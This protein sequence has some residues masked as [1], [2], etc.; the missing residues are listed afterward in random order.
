ME[1]GQF[2]LQGEAKV[3]PILRGRRAA[4]AVVVGG[5]LS[6]LTIAL[7]LCK[8]GLRVVLLEAA[9]LGGGASS[10]CAGI[11]SLWGGVSYQRLEKQQGQ[12]VLAAYGQTQQNA[13]QSLRELACD[14][15]EQAD[16]HD[17]DAHIVVK[18][19][20]EAALWREAEAMARAGLTAEAGKATQSPFPADA[21]ISLKDMATLHPM[22]HL[23]YLAKEGERLGLKIFEHSRVTALETNLVYTERGSVIAPYIVVATG[24]PI[25]NVPGW[26]FLRL[27]QKRGFLIPMEESALFEG[28]YQDYA[29]GY[30]LRRLKKG[31]LLQLNGQRVGEVVH[32]RPLEGFQAAY[33]PYM[34]GAR[35]ERC[36]VGVETFSAD[37]LPYI[38]AY[39]KRTPNLF[40]AAGYGG[41][42]LIG[43]MIAAQAISAKVLGLKNDGDSVYAGQRK[44][45][46][47]EEAKTFFSI[48]G[49]YAKGLIHFS[50]PR[51]PHLGC[52]LKYRPKERLWECPCHGSRFDDIGHIINAPSTR[53]ASIRHRRRG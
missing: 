4:D 3:H 24:Y 10:R 22:K 30:A 15:K 21:A 19:P 44:G 38:G 23:R 1:Q 47:A 29:G 43:S 37:G 12:A 20:D 9:V 45:S 40:V 52:K 26:Y 18:A 5:G 8:A 13:L 49:R 25:V 16:W 11:V 53:D 42:G 51:C 2:W 39:S 14:Q 6:G 36:F 33:A 28:V 46:R 7:W 17:T 50:A 31:M 34:E 32:Q 48:S 41:R 27:I 35:P